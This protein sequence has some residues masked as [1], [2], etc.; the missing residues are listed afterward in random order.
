MTLTKVLPYIG[1]LITA[2][3]L[4]SR[5]RKT[6]SILSNSSEVSSALKSNH[7]TI[8]QNIE[9]EYIDEK[10]VINDLAATSPNV[11]TTLNITNTNPTT[12]PEYLQIQNDRLAEQNVKLNSM[13]ELV[14][15][16]NNLHEKS[17]DLQA[18]ANVSSRVLSESVS[19]ILPALVVQFQEL[20]KLPSILS[21]KTD[22]ETAYREQALTNHEQLIQTLGNLSISGGAVNVVN[23]VAVPS[24]TIQNDNV[25][26][27]ALKESTDAHVQKTAEIASKLTSVSENATKQK[28]IAD[29]KTTPVAI[30]N[31]DGNIVATMKPMEASTVKSITDAK[32]ATDEMEFE[33]DDDLLDKIFEAI[34]LQN[35]T[36]EDIS[37]RYRF[38]REKAGI[39]E[40]NV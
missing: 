26:I 24:V 5:A 38:A 31:L 30:K 21:V 13:I 12:M 23:E 27:N 36:K 6:S 16:Q 18:K 25:A 3:R 35:F 28:E 29:Y 7:S 15:H 14:I 22:I 32:N 4:Y 39:G 10:I 34:V 9:N 2:Y 37:E 11:D 8:V 20:S 19:T 17:L 33:L 1:F 40:Y